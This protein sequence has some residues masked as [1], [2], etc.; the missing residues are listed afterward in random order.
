MTLPLLRA[1]QY[2]EEKMAAKPP[3]ALKREGIVGSTPQMRACLELLAQAAYSNTNVLIT[4][5]TG[6][7][8][9]LFASAIHHNSPRA[10]GNFVV[11]DCTALPDT[12]VESMLFGHEKGAFTGA[13]KSHK[14]L[15]KQADRGT[16]FLDEVGELPPH[17]QK[18]FLRGLQ[19]RRFRPLGGK[20]EIESDFR[21]VA[22]TNRDLDEMVKEGRFRKDLLFRLKTFAIEMPLLRERQGDIRALAMY[23][24]ARL[25]DRYGTGTK[26]FSP[27]FLEALLAYAWPGNVR[28]LFNAMERALT[29]AYM[30]PTLFPK[31][32]PTHI[33]VELS[34]GSIK[35]NTPVKESPVRMD[36]PSEPFPTLKEFRE[37]L[38]AEGEKKYLQDLLLHCNGDIRETCRI[39]GLG[40]ARFYGLIKKYN[41][42]RPR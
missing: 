11:V 9:E 29:A 39:S 3:V 15:I 36:A 30:E 6:T 7:G 32:L 19:E 14:G 27:E 24:V 22:A 40:R 18:A 16:L 12:L 34:R 10:G 13:D 25:S 35:K 37:A 42:S 31:H 21:L 8:K 23:H 5:E 33:R 26:G 28:E 17:V 41:I 38:L 2:R 4:G 20:Q 1:L